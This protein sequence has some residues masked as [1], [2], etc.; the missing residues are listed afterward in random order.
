MNGPKM[1]D[2]NKNLLLASGLSFLV[3][4]LWFFLFPPEDPV[5]VAADAT[6]GGEP[7]VPHL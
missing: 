5:N 1:D 4:I 7:P 6:S 2:Q 3:I